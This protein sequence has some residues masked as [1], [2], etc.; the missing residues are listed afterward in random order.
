MSV[1]DS[2]LDRDRKIDENRSRYKD[3]INSNIEFA[4]V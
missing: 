2:E 3:L 1:K 4:F